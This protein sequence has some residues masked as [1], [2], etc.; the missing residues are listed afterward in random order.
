MAPSANLKSE[1]RA[2]QLMLGTL[3]CIPFA[4]G[5]TSMLT[6]TKKLPGDSSQVTPTL[7]SEY[8]FVNAF[9]LSTA[10]IIWSTLPQIEEDSTTLRLVMGT[11][12]IGGLAR[13]VS[14]RKTGR[15]HPVFIGAIVL[16]LVGMP[17]IAVWQRRL[18]A[19]ESTLPI[20]SPSR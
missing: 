12:F 16:E 3:A 2:L 4:T 14:W 17:L 15:P 5:L 18:A 10:P 19:L 6:G 1:R 8:R 7:D 9:W 11:V 13:L 20:G